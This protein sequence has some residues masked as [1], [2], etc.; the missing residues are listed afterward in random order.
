VYQHEYLIFD[1]SDLV[2]EVGGLIGL[3][4]GVSAYQTATVMVDFFAKR[5]VLSCT[6]T[7]SG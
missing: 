2:G 5:N 6:T 4:L 1:W 7:K 3:F